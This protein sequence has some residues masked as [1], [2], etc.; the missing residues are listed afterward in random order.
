MSREEFHRIYEQMPEDFRAELIGG[1][2]YVASPLRRGHGTAHS[3]F[4]AVLVMYMASTPG[5]EVGDN[6]TVILDEKKRAAAGSIFADF[7]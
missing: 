6:T 1:T 2:V 7:P 3:I 5:V 4:N